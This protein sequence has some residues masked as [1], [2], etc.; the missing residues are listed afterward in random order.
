MSCLSF[1][2]VLFPT[3]L[4]FLLCAMKKPAAAT[5]LLAVVLAKRVAENGT[6]TPPAADTGF[7][8]PA[9]QL[10][11]LC[12]VQIEMPTMPTPP[13]TLICT[14]QIPGR[15]AWCLVSVD[16]VSGNSAFSGGVIYAEM[17]ENPESIV[18]WGWRA[19]HLSVVEAKKVIA[20]YYGKPLDYRYYNGCATGG[21]QGLKEIE[22]FPD[23]FDGAVV[24]APAWW[25]AHLLLFNIYAAEYN[26]PE[27]STHHIS[28]DLFDF[29]AN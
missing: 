5:A 14:Y 10:P 17:A 2:I 16:R 3:Y 28:S 27:H 12:A 18:D 25:T 11:A 26:L 4:T 9:Y 6:F 20:A 24:G 23:D 7:P 22:A 13:S 21:R 29:I 15:D 8:N 19:M 1:K